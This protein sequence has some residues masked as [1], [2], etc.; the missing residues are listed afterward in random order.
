MAGHSKWA[1]IQHRKGAQDKK[2]GKLFTKLIREIT[3][4]ARI[5][6]FL[7]DP[8]PLPEVSPLVRHLQ[9]RTSI[10][11]T[12]RTIAD[13][14][15]KEVNGSLIF[16]FNEYLT[17]A[18]FTRYDVNDNSF[19]GTRYFF[20]FLSPQKCWAFDFGIVDK[21]NPSEVEFRLSLSLI[22]ITSAGKSAF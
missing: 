11:V 12:Y 10:R 1:N 9:R 2:R 18:Y 6:G 5:G 17:A 7:R 16:R 22:G 3:V 13:R 15:L 4:A 19:I 20:R 14:L 21:V 8:R